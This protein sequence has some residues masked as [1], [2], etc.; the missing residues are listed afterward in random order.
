MSQQIK[1]ICDGCGKENKIVDFLNE[2]GK[3]INIC[4]SCDNR[5]GYICFLC[6]EIH[7]ATWAC[8]VSSK[9]NQR[10]VAA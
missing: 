4:E 3:Q 8:P 9:S 6:P 1:T 7:F 2:N 10:E 5:G